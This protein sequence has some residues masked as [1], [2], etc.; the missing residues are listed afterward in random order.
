MNVNDLIQWICVGVIFV[1]VAGW[2]G[3]YVRG[4]M[5]WSKGI[6]RPGGNSTPPCCGGSKE[7]KKPRRN[8]G[9]CAGCGEDCPLAGNKKT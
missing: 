8:D 4:V 5:K 1:I 2:I 7:E 3:R 9:P 6:K